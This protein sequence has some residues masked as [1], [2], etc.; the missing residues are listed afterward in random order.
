MSERIMPKTYFTTCTIASGASLSAEID[1]RGMRLTKIFMPS[2]WTTASITFAEAEASGGTF[3][4]LT[5]DASSPAEVT[6]PVAASKTVVIGTNKD[7]VCAMGYFKVRSGTV[8]SAVNQQAARTI[9]LLF[10]GV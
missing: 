5:T 1:G 7:S 6:I 8:G 9:G 10:T 3:D 2:A 4:P